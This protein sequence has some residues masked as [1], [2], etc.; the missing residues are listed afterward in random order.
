M[1]RF[2]ALQKTHHIPLGQSLRCRLATGSPIA[3][4]DSGIPFTV[5][6]KP[7]HKFL[8]RVIAA[9]EQDLVIFQNPNAGYAAVLGWN[10]AL[11]IF[12]RVDIMGPI[13]H[14]ILH[15]RLCRPDGHRDFIPIDG[16]VIGCM[17][18][19]R[20][21]PQQGFLKHNALVEQRDHIQ[22]AE[23]QNH[24]R[25]NQQYDVLKPGTFFRHL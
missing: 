4:M 14:N 9:R 2:R 8:L 21:N 13:F 23:Q 18:C 25:Q 16:S 11:R 3:E 24:G 6:I 5:F 12:Y 1:D 19:L 15:L 17:V 20:L 10:Q 7:S 22:H